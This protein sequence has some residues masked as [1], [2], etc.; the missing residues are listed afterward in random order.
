ML[1]DLIKA[2]D[3]RYFFLATV[4]LALFIPLY[5]KLP[6]VNVPGTYVA[7]R[8][9]DF[10]IALVVALWFLIKVKDFKSILKQPIFQAMILF[11]LIG[12]LSVFS[13]YF[14]THSVKLSLGVLEWLRRVEYMSLFFVAATSIRSVRQVKFLLNVLLLVT[15]LVSFYGLGQKW[16]HFPVIST[17]NS[18]L[19]K[20]QITYIVPGTDARI[21]STF[22]GHYD[23][24]MYLAA[25]LAILAALFFYVKR[26]YQRGVM[27]GTAALSVLALGLTAA[28]TSFGAAFLGI[29]LTLLLTGKR[30]LIIGLVI[31]SIV[32]VL[33]IPSLRNRVFATLQ[34]NILHNNG[35]TYQAPP[36]QF[37]SS[38]LN[39]NILQSSRAA[40]LA[41]SLGQATI[42]ASE[43]AKLPVDVAP[44]EPINV[45]DLEVYRSAGIRFN[46]EWP[47]AIAAFEKNPL[48]GT[49]YSSITLATDN[50]FLRSLGETGLL[51]TIALVLVF[52]VIFKRMIAY[53]KSAKGFPKFF[54]IGVL[55]ALTGIIVTGIFI[56]TL[57]SSKIAEL[58]WLILGSSWA[59]MNHYEDV[60]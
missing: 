19:S 5:P 44:G 26:W 17:L 14:V 37:N 20:G 24:A 28:R 23:L 3:R 35:P 55:S 7:V 9:E 22:A 50:D 52:V 29:A 2:F 8:L 56:D 6:A 43:N 53:I 58:L 42:S 12:G 18:E 16:L 32:A 4:V 31:V 13:A 30:L 60:K 54:I 47:R 41:K 57:E 25:V 48:L 45:T 46:V 51:G 39:N 36:I 34:V 33:A 59:L 10:L 1:K 38:V 21:N 27:I 15:I 49:G 40:Y 11:W